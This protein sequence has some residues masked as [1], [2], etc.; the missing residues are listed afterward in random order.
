MA[1]TIFKMPRGDAEFDGLR[2]GDKMQV[3]C[4]IRKEGTDEACLVSVDGKTVPG[5]SDSDE[6]EDEDYEED[7]EVVEEE[8]TLM[9]AMDEAM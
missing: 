6:E 8:A 4:V 9:D 3:S 2:D 1:K 7:E 5:Y